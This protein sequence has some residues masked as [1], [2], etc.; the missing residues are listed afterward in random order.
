MKQHE[1]IDYTLGSVL[2]NAV[3]DALGAPA[4]F[5]PRDMCLSR[6]PEGIQKMEPAGQTRLKV[7]GC[8][9]DDTEMGVALGLGILDAGYLHA[10]SIAR[11][12]GEWYDGHPPDVGCH[13]SGILRRI[14]KDYDAALNISFWSTKGKQDAGNGSVMRQGIL[15]PY[16]AHMSVF[17][18]M[19]A[20]E[21]QS[22]L[23]HAAVEAV[24]SC[25]YLM[26]L[27]KLFLM[28]KKPVEAFKL[29]TN[30]AEDAGWTHKVR[31][32][33]SR[34][35]AIKDAKHLPTTGYVI[36]TMD[37]ALWY[38]L[39]DVSFR[40]GLSDCVVHGGDADS[41]GAVCGAMLG[42]LHGIKEIPQEWLDDVRHAEHIREV[43]LDE[44][45]ED[46]WTMGLSHVRG[47]LAAMNDY[48]DEGS[49]GDD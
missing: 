11:R 6:W 3:G 7:G 13:T 44:L 48:E 32:I 9:T 26:F 45:H 4:E 25:K 39:Q 15:L 38:L 12:F 22:T 10:P 21:L 27:Q 23:T 40:E 33:Y 35:Q 16:V 2:G 47:T 43:T 1:M 42:T 8:Y 41:A 5:K 14:G 17:E 36:D 31:T 37:R 24:D 20:A 49:E 30:Y 18:A 29:V 19:Q 34:L 28:G 46:L